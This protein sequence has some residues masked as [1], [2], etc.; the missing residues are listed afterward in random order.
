MLLEFK[1]S[2]IVDQKN[3]INNR[4]MEIGKDLNKAEEDLKLFRDQNR[5][6]ASSAALLLRK[7]D[8]IVM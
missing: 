3:F 8:L 1:L 5:F 2:Q 7:K 4:I 6:I